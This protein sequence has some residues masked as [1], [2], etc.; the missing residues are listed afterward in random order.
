MLPGSSRAGIALLVTLATFTDLLAYSVAVPILPD[1]MARLGATPTIIGFLFAAFGL[2]L[3][4]VSVPA[5]VL[6]DRIGRRPPMVAGMVVLALSTL[7]FAYSTRL[8]WL[9]VARLLQG[10]ADAV[11]WGVGFALIA[12]TF[13]PSERG[14]VMGLV[15]S[16]SNFGFMLGPSIGGWLYERG[17]AALPFILVSALS[18]LVAGGFLLMPA[19]RPASERDAPSFASLVRDP[20]MASCVLVVIV[21]SSTLSMFEPVLSLFLSTTIG[22]SP[23]QV[24]LVFGTA[25]VGSALLH[26]VNG[27]LADRFGSR[28]MMLI[29]LVAAAAVMPLLA[30][31]ET[32][33]G[34]LLLFLLQAATMSVVVAPSLSY[35]AEVSANT[36][37]GS[38]GV[39]YG[40]YNFAWGC[41]LLAGPAVGGA[42]YERIGFLRLLVFWPLLVLGAA[43]WL[44]S[45][46][47]RRNAHRGD[48][49]VVIMNASE[50][51]V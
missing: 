36:S 40:L 34:A 9:F 32:Y 25:A 29:G 23:R 30:R 14:R 50:D 7:L 37:T 3:L 46:H 8:P 18:L 17:G 51:K 24:G 22:L 31:A 35:M 13:G 45:Q 16:G 41:G 48:P 20:A 15:M 2:S 21:M 33:R 38:F 42:L 10:A 27:R 1:L 44:A 49:A 6:S 39:S 19:Q 26:P 28:R 11:A 4:A 5:G 47:R 12:D 43:V